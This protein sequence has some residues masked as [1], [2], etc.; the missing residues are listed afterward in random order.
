MSYKEPILQE[1]YARLTFQEGILPYGQMLDVIPLLRRKGFND[2]DM[3]TIVQTSALPPEVSETDTSVAPIE[4][5]IR[6][7]YKDKTRLIQLSKDEVVANQTKPYQGWD[8]FRG[9]VNE[10]FEILRESNIPLSFRSVQLN[11]IDNFTT[12]ANASYRMGDWVNCDGWLIPTWYKDCNLSCDITLGQ[13]F[14][15]RDNVNKQVY[16]KVRTRS[17]G[18][19]VYF[20]TSLHTALSSSSDINN[21]LEGLHKES[22]DIFESLI[23][24]R[25]RNDLMKGK[26]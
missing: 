8:V 18:V 14:I 21:I 15:N 16:V 17:T 1:I 23:T 4:T 22:S 26:V 24:D 10:T 5:R 25:V 20:Q 19:S 7:W 6:C 13:G 2:I 11:L 12:P 9:L 3:Q